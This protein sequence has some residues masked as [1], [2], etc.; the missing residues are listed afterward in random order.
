VASG[1]VSG[2]GTG[3]HIWLWAR[4]PEDDF[5]ENYKDDFA[6]KHENNSVERYGD[7]FVESS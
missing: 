4:H 6:E 2:G 5:V 1:S 7:G 3:A